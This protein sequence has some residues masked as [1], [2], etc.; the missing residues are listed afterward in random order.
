[1]LA[2]LLEGALSGHTASLQVNHPVSLG[3]KLEL[4]GHQQ[5]G[6][7]LEQACRKRKPLKYMLLSNG[8]AKSASELSVGTA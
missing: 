3:H 2:D 7:G 4:V 6:L 1:M 5:A 8:R